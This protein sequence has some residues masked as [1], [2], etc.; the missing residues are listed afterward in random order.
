MAKKKGE[1]H[2]GGAWKVAYADFMTAMMALFMVL[3]ILGQNPEVLKAAA[4]YFKD[5]V[6]YEHELLMG[7]KMIS[8][9]GAT[10]EEGSG[11]SKISKE[12]LK[13]IAESIYQTLNLSKDSRDKPLDIFVTPDGVEM[14]IYNHRQNPI[15]DD[16]LKQLSSFGDLIIRSLAWTLDQYDGCLDIS[17][18]EPDLQEQTHIDNLQT[19]LRKEGVFQVNN[20]HWHRSQALL[21]TVFN[22]LVYHG[23]SLHKVQTLFI[24]K[25]KP[26]QAQHD[27]LMIDLSLHINTE[28]IVKR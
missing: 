24:D 1:G 28:T 11:I 17:I 18:Y 13:E 23:F 22:R 2:H 26:Q 21:K 3:W 14:M 15:F 4:D 19:Q 5:P 16:D 9:Q 20:D 25:M 27:I 12:K 7:Q 10:G 6:A 8:G